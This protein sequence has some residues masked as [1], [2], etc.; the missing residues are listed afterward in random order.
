MQDYSVFETSNWKDMSYFERTEALQSL[1]IAMAA[2]QGRTPRKVHSSDLPPTTRGQYNPTDPNYIYINSYLIKSNDGN[3][4]AVQ[5]TLHEGRHAYQDDCVSGKVV[6]MHKDTEKVCSWAINMPGRGGVYNRDGV[7]YRYQPVEIDA[8]DYAKEKMNSLAEQYSKDPAFKKFCGR[9]DAQD[10]YT[11]TRA[12]FSY[13][14]EYKEIIKQDISNRYLAQSKLISGN[15]Q[16]RR[17]QEDSQKSTISQ[18]HAKQQNLQSAQN[19]NKLGSHSTSNKGIET[20]RSRMP[21]SNMNT[22]ST[23][24]KDSYNKGIEAVRLKSEQRQ[25]SGDMTQASKSPNKGIESFVNRVSEQT[26]QYTQGNMV[27]NNTGASK[28]GSKSN[29]EGQGR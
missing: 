16:A 27:S 14:A 1:E 22:P 4:Q 19:A 28:K 21:N 5:T 13:G 24:G 7:E 20:M 25:K 15:E 10:R 8:N 18:S 11:E 12:R 6:S 29:S 23:T 9:S 2:E 3:Y 26:N 17:S